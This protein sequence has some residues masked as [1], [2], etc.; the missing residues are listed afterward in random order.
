M[1]DSRDRFEFAQAQ[2]SLD[3]R[4]N[5]A[6]DY[7][8]RLKAARLEIRLDEARVCDEQLQASIVD[9]GSGIAG[10]CEERP[11][12][13]DALYDSISK[14]LANKT[15]EILQCQAKNKRL[16]KMLKV[17]VTDR[18][19]LKEQLR[20]AAAELQELRG[21]LRAVRSIVQPQGAPP[22]THPAAPKAMD[23]IELDSSSEDESGS[24]PS[25]AAVSRP[26]T[27]R[28]PATFPLRA[29]TIPP[30]FGDT[31]YAHKMTARSTPERVALATKYSGTWRGEWY[32]DKRRRK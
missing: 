23:V 1:H 32:K 31:P 5:I 2:A 14:K 9:K 6:R 11:A 17:T 18:D 24:G 8:A 19:G 3:M 25:S 21:K 10:A 4:S 16:A 12:A 7:E 15:A 22:P 13:D 20:R 28:K 26:T 29:T 27:T 30:L